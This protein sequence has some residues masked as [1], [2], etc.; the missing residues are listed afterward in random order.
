MNPLRTLH[1]GWPRCQGADGCRRVT[2]DARGCSWFPSVIRARG[3][4]DRI[5]KK[6]GKLVKKLFSDPLGEHGEK[7]VL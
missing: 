4:T 3:S 6:T 5:F 1:D 7:M 2:T